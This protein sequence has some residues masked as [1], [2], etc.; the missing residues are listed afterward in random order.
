M[1]LRELY[2][3]Q[4]FPNWPN[5]LALLPFRAGALV[6]DKAGSFW[7]ECQ[8]MTQLHLM[9]SVGLMAINNSTGRSLSKRDNCPIFPVSIV[10]LIEEGHQQFP[11]K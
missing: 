6:L 1:I 10:V 9:T 3:F 7:L 5:M 4:A 2:N 11:Q 8:W